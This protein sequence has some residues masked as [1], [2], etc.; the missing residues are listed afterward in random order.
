MDIHVI[1]QS[2]HSYNATDRATIFVSRISTD[3]HCRPFEVRT[4]VSFSGYAEIVLATVPLTNEQAFEISEAVIERE[5]E[6]VFQ[7]SA[8]IRCH[9][10]G[11]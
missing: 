3:Q 4:R 5:R 9:E 6:D 7:G 10:A 1:S 8:F 2:V 11:R